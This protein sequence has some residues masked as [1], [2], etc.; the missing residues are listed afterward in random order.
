[1]KVLLSIK[2]EFAHKIFNGEKKFEYRKSIFK[3]KVDTVV[4]YSTMPEGKLIGEFKIDGIIETNPDLLWNE[5]KEFSGITYEFFSTYFD[6]R[7]NAYAIKI[8]ELKKYDTPI[9]P[10]EQNKNFTAPQSF[11]YID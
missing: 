5:T 4:V 10:K 8:G 2:P 3:Q 9:N 7:D 1:M 11:C 6:Q